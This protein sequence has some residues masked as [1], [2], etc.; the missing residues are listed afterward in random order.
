MRKCAHKKGSV[1]WLVFPFNA[2]YPWVHAINGTGGIE[3]ACS[4]TS[5][6]SVSFDFT[7]FLSTSYVW[8]CSIFITIDRREKKIHA[9]GRQPIVSNKTYRIKDAVNEHWQRTV[10]VCLSTFHAYKVSL[11]L[12]I[13]FFFFRWALLHL[14]RIQKFQPKKREKESDDTSTTTNGN[15]INYVFILMINKMKK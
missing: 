6:V 10:Y 15:D 7:P 5:N 3:H 9:Q 13:L 1:G 8:M 4:H 12:S 11:P 14:Y 2:I